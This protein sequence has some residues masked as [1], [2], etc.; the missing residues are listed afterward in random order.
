MQ[1]NLPALIWLRYNRKASAEFDE[2][3]VAGVTFGIDRRQSGADLPATDLPAPAV[4]RVQ[5]SA[6]DC[7]LRGNSDR[8]VACG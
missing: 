5:V 1:P 8:G 7:Y 6:S 2:D 3:P 4:I